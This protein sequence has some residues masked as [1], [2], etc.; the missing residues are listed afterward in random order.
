MERETQYVVMGGETCT[1]PNSFTECS[2]A[3]REMALYHWSYI[4]MDFHEGTIN[5]WKNRC[6]DDMKRKLGYRFALN[7]SKFTGNPVP[8]G[9]LKIEL[10]L[11]NE[12]FASPYNRRDVQ[13]VLVR[14]GTSEKQVFKLNDD[15]R[16]WFAGKTVKVKAD[17]TLPQ[18]LS[19]GLYDIYLNLSDPHQSL[20]HRPE[21]SIRLANKGIWEAQTGYNKL[22]TITIQ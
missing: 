5:S 6:M 20:A 17:I 14:K 8:G 12:G 22:N 10:E 4:N 13:I 19:K 21:Y 11:K 7:Y 1:S 18:H 9:H 2:N 15:P 16:R 3:L